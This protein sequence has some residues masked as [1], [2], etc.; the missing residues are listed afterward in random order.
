MTTTFYRRPSG[1]SAV[2]P[3]VLPQPHHRLAARR[4]NGRKSS[5]VMASTRGIRCLVLMAREQGT[6]SE[7]Q[8]ICLA[9][10]ST[11]R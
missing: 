10:S 1:Q 6:D 3:G 9:R 8:L 2:D 11:L 7:S 5:C 4:S